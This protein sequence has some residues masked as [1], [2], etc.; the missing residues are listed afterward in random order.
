VRDLDGWI[1]G[2]FTGQVKTHVEVLSTKIEVERPT[3]AG[4]RYR[5]LVLDAEYRNGVVDVN[6]LQ[7]L[8]T[9]GDSAGVHGTMILPGSDSTAAEGRLEIDGMV[10]GVNLD[11]FQPYLTKHTLRGE[12]SC[13]IGARGTFADPR[14]GAVLYLN[15][16]QVDTFQVEKVVAY[17]RYDAGRV[18]VEEGN[19]ASMGF[20][21]DFHGSFPLQLQFNPLRAQMISTGNLQASLQGGGNL[22]ALI[23]PFR[24]QVEHIDGIITV[25]IEVSGTIDEPRLDG[26]VLLDNG[27]LKPAALGQAVEDIQIDL[28]LSESEV[29]V[30]TFTGRM[31]SEIR[32][33]RG[34]LSSLFGWLS[35]RKEKG[36]DFSVTGNVTIEEGGRPA[37]DL[38]LKGSGLGISD[39]TGS[40][41]VVIDPDL[42]LVTRPGNSYPSLDGKV[43]VV[44]GLADVGMLLNMFGGSESAA[45][46]DVE[47]GEGLEADVEIEVPG[48]LRIVGGELGQDVD[49]ELMGNLLIRK[50]PQ[51]AP[52]LLG[53]LESVPGRGHLFM[54][55]QRWAIDEGTIT[56]GT[57]EEIN[58]GLNA[59]FSTNVQDVFVLLTLTGTVKE[60]LTQLST[61]GGALSSQR[62][63]LELLMLGRA[64]TGAEETG[65]GLVSNYLENVVNRTAQDWI[66]LDT[67]EMEGIGGL[68]QGSPLEDTRVSVGSYLGNKLYAKYAQSFGGTTPQQELGIEY[69]ISRRFRLSGMYDR[70]RRFLLELKW[71]IDY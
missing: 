67:V 43:Q 14:L 68:V 61:E 66:G 8:G 9:E 71:R 57:I 5:S 18:W 6:M 19:L 38:N 21:A 28:E 35:P 50:N 27:V 48:R 34:L 1:G 20:M 24:E 63:I 70:H 37:F 49:V 11:V 25:D 47:E 62:D 16:A 46:L 40:L 39:P 13:E 23:Q 4:H 10:V 52:Y 17:L 30:V 51:S 22:E 56:F 64:E 26:S 65:T 12:L 3:V 33:R 36:G 69:W 53:S 2:S 59:R 41:A 7:V 44:Q 31:P 60:P 42:R 55:F 15:G 58:P 32:R 54:F 45:E 29:R